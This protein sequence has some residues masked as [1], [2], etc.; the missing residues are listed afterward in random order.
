MCKFLS[1]KGFY[2]YVLLIY[3]WIFSFRVYFN[4]GLSHKKHHLSLVNW[5]IYGIGLYQYPTVPPATHIYKNFNG[6]TILV[7]VI[8]VSKINDLIYRNVNFKYTPNKLI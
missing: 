1:K 3:A 6:R 7:P 8:H 2:K 5:W 4:Q